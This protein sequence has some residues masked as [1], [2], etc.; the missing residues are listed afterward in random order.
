MAD[1]GANFSEAQTGAPVEVHG[2]NDGSSNFDAVNVHYFSSAIASVDSMANIPQV[3]QDK[4][5]AYGVGLGGFMG[6]TALAAGVTYRFTKNDVFKASV[7]SAMNSSDSN[8]VGLGAAW[9]Y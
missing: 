7:S 9:S 5:Y 8:A 2:V 4:S 3:D 1:N 6:K